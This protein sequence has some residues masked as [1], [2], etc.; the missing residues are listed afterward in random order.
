MARSILDM[1]INR[2]QRRGQPMPEPLEVGAMLEV[3]SLMWQLDSLLPEVD[4]LSV[5]SN[6]LFQ[7][8]FAVDRGHPRVAGRYD[9][10][11]LVVHALL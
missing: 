11:L 9:R 2:A 10:R 3:P 6:D 1:E 8:L 4:F 5:G 7:F